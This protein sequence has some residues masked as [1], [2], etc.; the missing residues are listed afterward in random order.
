MITPAS[1]ASTEKPAAS[2]DVTLG[3][4]SEHTGVFQFLQ[5]PLAIVGRK[6]K[7]AARLAPGQRDA[8]HAAEFP[9]DPREEFRAG[10]Q[11]SA[12]EFLPVRRTCHASL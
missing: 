3:V 12:F 9:G 4:S 10:V 6:M 11:V 1:L 7:Q 5:D 2:N 8:R